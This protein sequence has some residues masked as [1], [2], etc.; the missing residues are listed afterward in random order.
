MLSAFCFPLTP[1]VTRKTHL[2]IKKRGLYGRVSGFNK[3]FLSFPQE[4]QRVQ[5]LSREQHLPA[6]REKRSWPVQLF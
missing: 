3:Y 1:Y 6:V 4:L 5:L 2:S